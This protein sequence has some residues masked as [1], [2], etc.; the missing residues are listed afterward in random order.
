MAQL[1]RHPYATHHHSPYSLLIQEGHKHCQQ[2]ACGTGMPAETDTQDQWGLAPPAT[3]VEPLGWDKLCLLVP[4][5]ESGFAAR[6]PVVHVL[7]Q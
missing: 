7:I 6:V 4:L 3:T 5:S 1:S 2:Q